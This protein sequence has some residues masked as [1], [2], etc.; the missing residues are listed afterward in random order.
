MN[1]RSRADGGRSNLARAVDDVAVRP[2]R[3]TGITV[4]APP[5]QS[6]SVWSRW[7]A[8]PALR[9][10][11]VDR[12]DPRPAPV[13]SSPCPNGDSDLTDSA[14]LTVVCDSWQFTAAP[15]GG[16][17]MTRVVIFEAAAGGI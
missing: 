1:A 16:L 14:H 10:A 8:A 5:K 13:A 6:A 3:V 15:N 7:P 9:D 12:T 2:W 11:R 4:R 17:S